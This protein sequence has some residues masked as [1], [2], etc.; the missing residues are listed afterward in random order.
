M[1]ATGYC[2]REMTRIAFNRESDFTPLSILRVLNRGW[3]TPFGYTRMD[4]R[5]LS[6]LLTRASAW[7]RRGGN[8]GSRIRF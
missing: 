4:L 8:C 1:E 5:V 3:R 6:L 2:C 7:G